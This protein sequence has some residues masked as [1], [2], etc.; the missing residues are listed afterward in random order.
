MWRCL[1]CIGQA[2]RAAAYS[3]AGHVLGTG[4]DKVPADVLGRAEGVVASTAQ[5]SGEAAVV[6]LEKPGA[7][8]KPKPTD[9]EKF[10]AWLV[11]NHLIVFLAL[12]FIA[13]LSLPGPGAAIGEPKADL[14]F[15]GVTGVASLCL[16]LIIFLISGFRLKTDAVVGALKSPRALVVAMVLILVVTPC[17]GFLTALLPLATK[18]ISYGLT[19]FC[20]VPTTLTSGAALVSGC[21]G[22][23]RATELALMITVATNLIGA[24]TTPLA[25][26]LTLSG[27]DASIDA[28]QLLGK[29]V[30]SILVPTLIG[31]ALRDYVPGAAA[32]SKD[33]K[34]PLTILSNACLCSIVWL[35]VSK[36]QGNIVTQP[37]DQIIACIL[38]G[39]G[40]HLVFWAI[41]F[42]IVTLAQIQDLHHS[43]AVWLLASEKTLPV[44]VAVIA[45][46]PAAFGDAGLI[47]LP[48][49][50]GHLSQLFMD[51]AVVNK[52]AQKPEE[53]ISPFAPKP[54]IRGGVLQR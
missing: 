49:I 2:P 15:L 17:V 19:V 7:P 4:K 6:D 36:A 50:F 42:P 53:A 41:N 3:G 54:S 46:L 22:T 33:K 25:L 51:A 20:C 1:T 18:E 34:V 35:S 52:W 29:L 14:G 8:T 30:V 31:K 38:C 32:F 13:G 28:A 5:E 21:R 44:S 10:Q 27:A 16:L 24:L 43:R 48:C 9:V 47:A 23:D 40:L 37:L 39:V 45:G 11:A 26:S 12:A